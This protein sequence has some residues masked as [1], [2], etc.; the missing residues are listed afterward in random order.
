MIFVLLFTPAGI[1]EGSRDYAHLVYMCFFFLFL[2][3]LE[4]V[5]SQVPSEIMWEVLLEYGVR[6]SLLGAIQFLY[7]Q[8][9]SCVRL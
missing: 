9:E 5:Y 6:G 4:K 2:F 3:F 1:I 7:G 8:S